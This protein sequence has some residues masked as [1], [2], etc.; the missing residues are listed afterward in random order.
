MNWHELIG[1][2][3]IPCTIATFSMQTMI[4]LRIMALTSNLVFI[5]SGLFG[6]SYTTFFMHLLL[7]PLNSWRLYQM[8][9][10]V[11]KV[12]RAS[13][14]DLS[15]E[16]LKHF[17]KKRPYQKGDVLFLKGDEANEMFYTLTGR[18]R[19]RELG[20]DIP[21]GQV[22]G[23]LGLL[24]PDN[25]RTQTLECA[26]DGEVLT[27]KYR[28]IMQLYFQNPT[29]G[30]YM[31]QLTSG[32]LFQNIARLEGELENQRKRNQ[33]LEGTLANGSVPAV[34]S[35]AP[36]PALAAPGAAPAG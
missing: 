27:V 12:R 31:L 28:D 26:E 30:L 7:L 10:L 2:L 36:A 35:A 15:M 18:F 13:R 4:P 29:F 20:I 3:A 22:V 16:W 21:S 9:T 1:Y 8:I 11:T 24:A 17:M 32:R 19:L 5:V 23:E 14:G 6:G 34:Q 25:R 33:E